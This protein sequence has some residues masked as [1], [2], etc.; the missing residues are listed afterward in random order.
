MDANA[1][2]EVGLDTVA[3]IENHYIKERGLP[4]EKTVDFLKKNYIDQ[5]KLGD[6]C[7][8]GGLLPPK[9]QR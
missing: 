9:S 6:K 8:I 1:N 7:E 5:G 4:S 3:F 2:A